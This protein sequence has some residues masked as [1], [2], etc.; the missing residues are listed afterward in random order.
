M[1]TADDIARAIAARIAPVD[2]AAPAL[3]AVLSP[4]L[5]TLTQQFAPWLA[6]DPFERIARLLTPAEHAPEIRADIIGSR[7]A[8]SLPAEWMLATAGL[9]GG[10]TARLAEQDY[11][12]RLGD[13]PE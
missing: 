10:E 1:S 6:A 3:A 4:A 7:V 8:N 2:S 11:R 9:S 5:A 13:S 12:R